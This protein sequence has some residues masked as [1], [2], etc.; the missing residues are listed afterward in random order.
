MSNGLRGLKLRKP[1]PTSK[2][3]QTAMRA[4]KTQA[5]AG[6]R[7]HQVPGILVQLIS[8][9]VFIGSLSAGAVAASA[10]GCKLV[11][12]HLEET[13]VTGPAC[14]SPVGLCTIARMFG[15]VQGEA[16]FTAS[17]II[18]SADT[19]TTSVVFV[20][21]DTVIVDAKVAG[22][23]G[24]LIVKNAAAFRATG[25]GDLADAQTVIGGTEDLAGATGSLRISGD[26]VETAGSSTYEGVICLP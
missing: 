12:G 1:Y 11:R 5:A 19:P 24:T 23:R 26:F 3:E 6:M 14:S 15:A 17:A 13:L 16:Q 2:L 18:P 20:I 21:G 4:M 7:F 8:A 10:A 25:T 9:L 22:H